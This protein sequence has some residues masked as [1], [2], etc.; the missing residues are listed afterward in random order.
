MRTYLLREHN[1]NKYSIF[2]T[3]LLTPRSWIFQ[4][5]DKT[6]NCEATSDGPAVSNGTSSAAPSSEWPPW[7][8]TKFTQTGR[9]AFQLTNPAVQRQ[10]HVSADAFVSIDVYTH[11]YP[12]YRTKKS[13]SQHF[14]RIEQQLSKG[15]KKGQNNE[16]KWKRNW[17]LK[18]TRKWRRMS[19]TQRSRG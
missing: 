10:A 12:R 16:N 14:D 1:E 9:L 11:S 13:W 19:I 7:C 8:Q 18:K 17:R 6:E 15:E 2:E 5:A 3:H 4:A